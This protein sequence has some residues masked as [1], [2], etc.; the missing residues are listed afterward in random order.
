M[1]K[2][3]LK[4]VAIILFYYFIIGNCKWGPYTEWSDCSK[5]C[6]GGSQNRTRVLQQT[7]LNGGMGCVGEGTQFRDCNIHGCPGK[8]FKLSLIT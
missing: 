3:N 4:K 7:A 6:D 1:L 2:C 8:S 5:E